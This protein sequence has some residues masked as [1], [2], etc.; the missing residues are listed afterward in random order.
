MLKAHQEQVAADMN[1]LLPALA[2]TDGFQGASVRAW[3]ASGLINLQVNANCEISNVEVETVDKNGKPSWGVDTVDIT[4]YSIENSSK[5]DP[6]TTVKL[7]SYE[8]LVK[9]GLLKKFC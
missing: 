3:N 5:G 9:S 8:D 6:T 4:K 7:Y 1:E 2:K